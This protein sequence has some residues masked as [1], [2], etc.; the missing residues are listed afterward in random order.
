MK[1]LVILIVAVSLLMISPACKNIFG[2]DDPETAN[3]VLIEGPIFE[4]ASFYFWVKGRVQN[5]GTITAT[6]AKITIFIRDAAG[7]LL[8]QDWSYIDDTELVAG[9]TSAFD[10]IIDDDGGGV[11][12]AMDFSKTTWEIKWD[13]SK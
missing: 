2:P 5:T 3:V 9:E 10:V 12:A 11:R 8:A 7:T 13:T 1:K 4:D 6:F